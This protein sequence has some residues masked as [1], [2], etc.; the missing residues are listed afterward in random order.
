MAKKNNV[1]KDS[2]GYVNPLDIPKWGPKP[3][4]K[5][6]RKRVEQFTGLRNE[7]VKDDVGA[8]S[9]ITI[10]VMGGIKGTSSQIYKVAFVEGQSLKQY[11]G[12][13]KLRRAAIY[14]AVYDQTNL[15]AGRCRISYVPTRGS[16]ITIGKSSVGSAT[17]FQ[18]SNHDA[19]RVAANM[20]GGA[21]VVERK[22]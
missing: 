11:L 19:Q 6:L 22:K 17:Q 8:D 12:R 9:H 13:L 14:N 18:R 15:Q 4:P 5:L 2:G 1:V 20:G 10:Q 7:A 21:K 16:H 3:K